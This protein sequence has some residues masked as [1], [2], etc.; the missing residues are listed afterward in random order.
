MWTSRSVVAPAVSM[1]CITSGP[2]PSARGMTLRRQLG[3]VAGTSSGRA[4]RCMVERMLMTEAPPTTVSV[5]MTRSSMETVMAAWTFG[6][7]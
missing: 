4:S 3:S 2:L 6:V 1:I 5:H 7:P